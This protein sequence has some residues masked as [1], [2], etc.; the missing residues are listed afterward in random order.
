MAERDSCM[1]QKIESASSVSHTP[2]G[3]D[4][5]EKNGRWLVGGV[6]GG[7]RPSKAR[8]RID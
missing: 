4:A 7:R 1:S 2:L 8:L 6:L 5:V 3:A